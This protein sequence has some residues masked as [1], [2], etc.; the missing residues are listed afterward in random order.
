MICPH[1]PD[2]EAY[3]MWLDMLDAD[4]EAD[5]ENELRY[6][7]AMSLIEMGLWIQKD[8]KAI[9][10]KEMTGSHIRNAIAMIDRNFSH[11]DDLT[12]EVAVA[13]RAAMK[14][15]LARRYPPIDPAFMY[16]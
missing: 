7:E 4:L 8:G 11:Y 12:A 13:W 14:K 6:I 2:T 5:Q 9:P 10:I 3:A 1:D 15:E 16:E